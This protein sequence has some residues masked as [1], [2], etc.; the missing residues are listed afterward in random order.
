MLTEDHRSSFFHGLEEIRKRWA[1]HEGSQVSHPSFLICSSG[2]HRCAGATRQARFTLFREIVQETPVRKKMLKSAPCAE[3]KT[4]TAFFF[5]ADASFPMTA[6][7]V[8]YRTMY[9]AGEQFYGWGIR[10]GFFAVLFVSYPFKK[11]HCTC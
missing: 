5:S 8:L 11:C 3:R 2:T 10:S 4:Y 9:E 1:P 6:N 7:A